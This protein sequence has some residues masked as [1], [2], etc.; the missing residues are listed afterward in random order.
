MIYTWQ[1]DP[2]RAGP[3]GYCD[4]EYVSGPY[5]PTEE[6]AVL[7]ARANVL[8]ESCN[9]R[10]VRSPTSS[11]TIVKL[12][13]DDLPLFKHIHVE[14][15]TTLLVLGDVTIDDQANVYKDS[16]KISTLEPPDAEF[17]MKLKEYPIKGYFVK[18]PD[19]IELNF[20]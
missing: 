20:R 15:T 1:S 10:D 8:R 5:F 16:E 2:C 14:T 17:Y 4:T 7:H 19:C 9:I 18:S 11:Y 6:L 13:R 12:D 3:P